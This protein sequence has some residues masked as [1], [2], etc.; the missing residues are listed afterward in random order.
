MKV[1]YPMMAGWY[2][3]AIA[4]VVVAIAGF[5]VM[6]FHKGRDHL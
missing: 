2:G 3:L 6:L 4:G 5:V 1:M